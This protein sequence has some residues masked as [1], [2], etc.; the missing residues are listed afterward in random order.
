M[1]K[2]FIIHLLHSIPHINVSLHGVHM[3]NSTFNPNSDVYIEVSLKFSPWRQTDKKNCPK[4]AAIRR[5]PYAKHFFR[6]RKRRNTFGDY[7]RSFFLGRHSKAKKKV[8]AK[9]KPNCGEIQGPP[10][11]TVTTC[12][13]IRVGLLRK[14]TQSVFPNRSSQTNK[15]DR[16]KSINMACWEDVEN[17]KKLCGWEKAKRDAVHWCSLRTERHFFPS[18]FIIITEPTK[19][20]KQNTLS[21][22]FVMH[23]FNCFWCFSFHL[24]LDTKDYCLIWRFLPIPKCESPW[25]AFFAALLSNKSRWIK[26]KNGCESRKKWS[27]SY[28][29]IAGAISIVLR[30]FRSLL[31]RR[32]TIWINS[33][34]LLEFLKSRL[35]NFLRC[36]TPLCVHDSQYR[37]YDNSNQFCHV[38]DWSV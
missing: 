19:S 26:G 2:S 20:R 34:S 32:I 22:F 17:R 29:Q 3:V 18:T 33:S 36:W 7:N 38:L 37:K 23:F 28:K 8:F 35:I 15:W 25:V 4:V 21:G 31:K 13:L 14:W 5:P 11:L 27:A 1:E 6:F 24:L 16:K 9:T 10:W 12:W 30:K